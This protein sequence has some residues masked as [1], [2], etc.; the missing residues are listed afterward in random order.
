MRTAAA[1]EAAMGRAPTARESLVTGWAT[2]GAVAVI[3][4]LLF[5]PVSKETDIYAAVLAYALLG[6]VLLIFIVTTIA[7]ILIRRNMRIS[8]SPP[9]QEHDGSN[10]GFRISSDQPTISVVRISDLVVPPLYYVSL[11]LEFDGRDVPPVR[12]RI[13]GSARKDRVISE[14]ITFPHRGLWTPMRLAVRFGDSLG[15]SVMNWEL[16]DEEIRKTFKVHPPVRASGDLPVLSSCNR[17]GDTLT[18]LNERKGDPYDLKPYQHSDGVRKILWKI[19]AKSGELI[20]RHPEPSMTPEGQVLVFATAS[21]E[22]DHV[23]GAVVSYLKRLEATNLE[24]FFGCEGMENRPL[25]HDADDAEELLI[26]CVWNT[27]KREPSETLDDLDGFLSKCREIIRDG[28]IDRVIV[29]GSP[30]RLLSQAAVDW[31]TLLG[32][33]LEKS[34]TKPVFF[35]IDRDPFSPVAIGNTTPQVARKRRGPIRSFVRSFFLEDS[36]D[37]SD[38]DSRLYHANFVNIC[39]NNDWQVII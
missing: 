5:G 23:C 22:E 4:F 33:L 9:S 19:Y 24:I 14:E 3:I 26:D 15:I 25:V 12:H 29:F 10:G 13:T 28:R 31:Y 37:R 36:A 16:S 6:F 8:I 27:P 38:G 21:R 32:K 18:D 11:R 1:A 20:S 34:H 17:P 39:L 30:Q 7:G 35:L 2:T